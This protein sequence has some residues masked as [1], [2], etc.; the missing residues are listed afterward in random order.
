MDIEIH[1]K[2]LTPERWATFSLAAQLMNISSEIARAE[3]FEKKQDFPH[4]DRALLRAHEL[5]QFSVAGA[6]TPSRQ[7]ELSRLKEMFLGASF[8]SMHSPLTLADIQKELEPFAGVL[9]RERG[10]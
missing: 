7:R 3:S 6:S 5:I 1:H 10:V 8:D 4:R 2:T 9:A